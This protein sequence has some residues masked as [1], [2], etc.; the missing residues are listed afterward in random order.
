MSQ[1]TSGFPS[2]TVSYDVMWCMLGC[3]PPGALY[4]L[5][6]MPWASKPIVVSFR[7][8]VLPADLPARPPYQLYVINGSLAV[9]WNH[10]KMARLCLIEFWPRGSLGPVLYV[11]RYRS[12]SHSYYV[13]TSVT[14]CQW[15]ASRDFAG[16]IDRV[17]F[18]AQVS[19]PFGTSY[20]RRVAW[21]RK[22]SFQIDIS[23]EVWTYCSRMC[24]LQW[25]S[26]QPMLIE[27]CSNFLNTL[28]LADESV[29][30]TRLCLY[31]LENVVS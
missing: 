11:S 18:Y 4:L 3:P 10:R 28:L 12:L 16:L 29:C 23:T 20:M 8:R 1:N 26:Q 2:L 6:S 30:N 21:P 24:T 27:L 7:G 9:G 19:L 14:W 5:H 17:K 31:L 25:I 15:H 13:T 22:C